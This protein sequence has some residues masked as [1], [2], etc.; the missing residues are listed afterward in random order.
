MQYRSPEAQTLPFPIAKNILN[1]IITLY[2]TA[3]FLDIQ[4]SLAVR[5]EYDT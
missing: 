3:F 4:L 2:D 1:R 5:N